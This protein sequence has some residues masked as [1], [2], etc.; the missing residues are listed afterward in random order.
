MPHLPPERISRADIARLRTLR[1]LPNLLK[2][3][4]FIALMAALGWSA[5]TTG[6]VAL[7]WLDYAAFGYLWMSIVTIM[8]DATH[9]ALFTSKGLNLA[10]GI[11][12]MIPIF[13]SF[14]AFKTDHLEHHRY[15]RS[16]RDQDAFMMGRRRLPD[17]LVFYA[18]LAI[19]GVLS[20]IHF[21]RSDE[22]RVG[23]GCVRLCRYRWSR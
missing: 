9:D 10:F 17:F 4:L 18:Y 7:R 2:M 20:F 8:H 21:N 23:K 15:N 12:M 14:I 1:V 16:P 19:G 22:R 5:W 6:S 13:A 3:P 11:V